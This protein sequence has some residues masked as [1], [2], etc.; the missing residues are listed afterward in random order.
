M[1]NDQIRLLRAQATALNPIGRPQ[2]TARATGSELLNQARPSL[3]TTFSRPDQFQAS[4]QSRSLNNLLWSWRVLGSLLGRPQAQGPDLAGLQQAL[5]DAQARTQQMRQHDEILNTLKSSAL[6]GAEE[7]VRWAYGLEADGAPLTVKLAQELGGALASVSYRYDRSGKMDQM[8]LNINVS[9]FTPQTGPNGVNEH[10]IENDRIIAHEITHA[11]MGRSMN[12]ALLPDWFMEGTAEYVA[13]GAERVALSLKRMSPGGLLGRV[14]QPWHGDSP[15]YA[16]AYLA[17]RYLDEATQEGGGIRQVMRHL[18]EGSSLDDAIWRVSGGRYKGESAFLVAFAREGEGDSWMRR[19]DLS[20]R[21]PGSIRPG[22]GPEIV[23]DGGA[24]RQ[25]PLQGFR[26][27]WPSPLE[28]I[29]LTGA[30]TWG[31]QVAAAAYSQAQRAL[32][33][34]RYQQ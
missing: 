17:V 29:A 10:V 22:R 30:W 16:A 33:P 7:L 12:V 2:P 9:Q 11:V 8:H 15:Q 20:G 23:P 5:R 24:P 32:A 25:Q 31:Q 13:G 1:A 4:A 34:T 3:A 14:L 18:Q 28:G 19:V 6:K 26:I 21:E 27:T